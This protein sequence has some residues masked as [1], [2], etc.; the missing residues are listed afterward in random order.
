M[1]KIVTVD[2]NSELW[3]Q[4]AREWELLKGKQA[5]FNFLTYKTFNSYDQS[6]IDKVNKELKDLQF[7]FNKTLNTILSLYRPSNFSENCHFDVNFYKGEIT[8]DE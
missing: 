7:S 6:V 8:F 1:S 4:G 3:K 5:L 2:V